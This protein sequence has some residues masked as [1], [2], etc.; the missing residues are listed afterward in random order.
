MIRRPRRNV[1]AVIVAIVLLAGCVLVVVAV[2]QS[3]LGQTPLVSL[4]Q[5]L[6]VTSAQQWT[7]AAVIAAAVVVAVLGLILLLAALRPG[8]PTVLPL[9][10]ITDSDGSPVADAGVRRNTLGKDLTTAASTVPGVV[11]ASVKT[12][13][14]RV[15]ATVTTA[16]KDPD[17]VPGQVRE[18]L[19]SRLRDIGFVRTPKVRVRARAEKST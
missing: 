19:E 18:H 17:A 11:S 16:A 6:S 15:T 5:L 10:R 3:L 9:A 1:P 14:A 7:S 12:G 8:N 13:K 2:V 4:P